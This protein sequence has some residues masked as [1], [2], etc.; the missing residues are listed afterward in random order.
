[1]K[2]HQA[3]SESA[4]GRRLDR[5]RWLASRYF[6]QPAE[7]RTSDSDVYESGCMDEP[8]RPVEHVVAGMP[9]PSRADMTTPPLALVE[10]GNQEPSM[11]FQHSVHLTDCRPLIV[12]RHVMQCE[13]A[14][15]GVEGGIRKRKLLGESD[16]EGRR[17][18]SFACQAV[19][20]VDHFD[21]CINAVDRAGGSYPL[22]E[23][24]SKAARSAAHIEHSV[25]GL[26]LQIIGLHRA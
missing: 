20:P 22:R 23:S 17:Y 8:E 24:D 26:K 9:K 15:D 10:L 12:L 25:A 21:C 16:L 19:R 2:N 13:R 3:L 11:R 6:A 7:G 14:C 1:V 4:L 5:G 18:P